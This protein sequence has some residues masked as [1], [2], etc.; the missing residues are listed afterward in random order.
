MK[1]GFLYITILLLPTFLFAQMQNDWGA[2]N[3]RL[4]AKNF[5]GKKFKLQAAVKVQLIDPTSE[6][7]IWVRVDRPNRKTGFFYNMM[8]KP[9]RVKEWSDFFN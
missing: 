2:F 1:K 3:Q 9:I 8:D 6:A 4:D 5:A 7:E